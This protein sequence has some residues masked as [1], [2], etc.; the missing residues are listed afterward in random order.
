MAAKGRDPRRER[1]WRKAMSAWRASGLGV[2]AYCRRPGLVET[3]FH[4]WRRELM[5]RDAAARRSA[6]VAAPRA[7]RQG[8]A[9]RRSTSAAPASSP[10]FVPVTVIP[11]VTVE[12]RCPSGHVVS[13]PAASLANADRD[14]LRQLFAALALGAPK[15]RDAEGRPPC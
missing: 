12:V 7:P 9:R 15:G 11:G 6:F 10:A 1:F 4:Y 2:R 5:R 14:A 3:S 13:L 8:R